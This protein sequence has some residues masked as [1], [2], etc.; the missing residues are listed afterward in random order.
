HIFYNVRAKEL[1]LTN[2]IPIQRSPALSTI[3]RLKGGLLQTVLVAV[4]VGKLSIRQALIPTSTILNSTSSQHIFQH[5]VGSLCLPICL[6]MIGGAETQLRI[7]RI[8]ELLPES[9]SELRPSVRYDLLGHT[10]QA[11]N[12][13]DV[14]LCKSST[15]VSSV[16]W[17]E[18][19]NLCQTIHY[20]PYGV[21][22]FLSTGQSNNEVHSDFLPFPLWNLQR[23]Q[24]TCWPLMLSLDT[25]TGVRNSHVLCHRTL[26]PIPPKTFLEIIIHLRAARMNGVS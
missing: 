23:L 4:V 20:Y 21:V 15:G 2:L 24:Q 14:Q 12:L 7:Q 10:M 19:S 11:D 6:K 1:L 13:R 8:M 3:Q 17:N 9:R 18:V 16:H 25:L 26:H 22:P 5:L